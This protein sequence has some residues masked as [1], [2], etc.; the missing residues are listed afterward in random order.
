MLKRKLK[1]IFF[2]NLKCLAGFFLIFLFSV[3]FYGCGDFH[4]KD[5]AIST[6]SKK[7]VIENYY[8][9]PDLMEGE[10]RR[11]LL[12]PPKNLTNYEESR[13]LLEESRMILEGELRLAKKFDIVRYQ[14]VLTKEQMQIVD[15]LN[16]DKQGSYDADAMFDIGRSANVQGILFT[17][18][19]RYKP[20]K[21]MVLG[22]KMNLLQIRKGAI[23]W[24]VDEVFDA[25]REDIKNLARYH[26]YQ[27]YDTSQNPSL[28]WD[29]LLSS[30]NEFAKFTVAE[31]LKTYVLYTPP[32]E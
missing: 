4:I 1:I 30:M 5:R 14:D 27:K 17:S 31:M 9:D 13:D 16:I 26:Y 24:A 8:V 12:V 20:V 7:Y 23:V 18:I 15:N 3:I 29:Y 19:T 21:P 11:V 2:K 32:V 28:K 10:I 22:V 25:S 6:I